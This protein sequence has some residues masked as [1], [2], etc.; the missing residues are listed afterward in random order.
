KVSKKVQ[1]QL[2][3]EIPKRDAVRTSE[4]ESSSEVKTESSS[5]EGI[6]QDLDTILVFRLSPIL[7]SRNEVLDTPFIEALSILSMQLEKE[8]KISKEKMENIKMNYF[9]LVYYHTLAYSGKY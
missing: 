6:K 5:D 1:R 3:Y 4:S 2:N 9:S 7:G 8:K